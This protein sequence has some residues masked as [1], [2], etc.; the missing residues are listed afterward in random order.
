MIWQFRISI[1]AF[2]SAPDKT[3]WRPLKVIEFLSCAVFFGV[4]SFI[5]HSK[6]LAVGSW[7]D[8]DFIKQT[9]LLL[10]LA[11]RHSKKKQRRQRIQLSYQMKE[12]YKRRYLRNNSF[13]VTSRRCFNTQKFQF[14]LSHQIR[15]VRASPLFMAAK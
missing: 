8:I 14:L 6:W 9:R 3:H 2:I 5:S 13:I 12:E 15:Y 10:R 4:I 7:R 1:S 11:L